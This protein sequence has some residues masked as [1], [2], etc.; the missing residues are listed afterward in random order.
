MATVPFRSE[1]VTYQNA[2][3]LGVAGSPSLDEVVPAPEPDEDGATRTTFVIND[4][5]SISF[6]NPNINRGVKSSD[7]FDANLAEELPDGTLALMAEDYLM[8][9]D[10]DI[11]SRSQFI[12]NINRGIDLLGTKIEEAS[13]TKGTRRSI[14]QSRHAALL[15]ACVRY[16]SAAR[17]EMLP[18]NGPVKIVTV[19]ASDSAEDQLASDFESDFNYYL[20]D[21]AKEYYPDTDRALFYQGFSGTVFK[22]VYRCPIRKRPVSESVYLQNLIVSEN[23]TDLDNAIRVTNE[24]LMAPTR[25]RRMQLAGGWRDIDLGQAMQNQGAVRRKVLESQGI[26]PNSTLPQDQQHTIYEGYWDIDPGDY[27]F[28]ESTAQDGLPLPYRIV[29]DRDSRKVLE[30][31]R[32]WKKDDEEFRR[33]KNF[34]KFG[35]IP[36]LGFLDYGY[37]HL[38]GNQTRVLTAILGILVDSGM[39]SNF[40]G[41]MK[42]KGVRM[43]TNE[44]AP[45]LGEWVDIDLNGSDDI[46]KV[47]TG[48]PYKDVSASLMALYESM[49]QDVQRMSGAVD[50]EVGEGRANVPVGTIMAMIEQ[51]TQVMGAV[52]KRN[53]TAQKEELCLLRDLFAEDP[54]ALTKLSRNPARK[55]ETAA[56]FQDLNLSPASDPNVPAQMHRIMVN[57]FLMQMAQQAPMLFGSKLPKV[58]K[59]ILT[60]IGISNA[61]DLL[62]SQEE[63]EQ[64]AQAMMK[65]Q[66]PPPGQPPQGQQPDPSKIAVA[67]MQLPLKQAQNDLAGKKLQAETEQNQREAANQAAQAQLK[68]TELQMNSTLETRKLDLQEQQLAAEHQREVMGMGLDANQHTAQLNHDATQAAL[69]RAQPPQMPTAPAPRLQRPK[70][71]GGGG[72]LGGDGT[73]GTGV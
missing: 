5:G 16:Q 73:G 72:G 6:V 15:E 67:Q 51:Q 46:S 41:G 22:K 42:A 17:A 45:G 35:L 69:T 38:I 27:G 66:Q 10:T 70:K 4:D 55:W 50:L 1:N 36:G 29:I 31:R 59:R 68:Q 71:P 60:S 63:F 44:V 25:V 49:A 28:S 23:A 47:I 13:T 34:V 37:V 18:A 56:E 48:M 24:I 32:N 7:A 20:T 8:G 33:R 21:I 2:A 52:H 39:L 3:G 19:G 61:D 64:T 14:S 62:A 43:G 65:P 57:T 9:V 26:A 40:P 12:A 53:H 11:A 54:A 58:A 30:V